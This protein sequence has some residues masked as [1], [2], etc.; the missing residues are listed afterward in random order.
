MLQAIRQSGFEPDKTRS[1]MITPAKLPA[2]L[3]G[4]PPGLFVAS[5]GL[6]FAEQKEDLF[7]LFGGHRNR[8]VDVVSQPKENSNDKVVDV[9]GDNDTHSNHQYQP[10]PVASDAPVFVAK[11]DE[12]ENGLPTV[13]C[14]EALSETSEDDSQ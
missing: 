10:S 4:I 5:S 1:G 13:Q 7:D 11:E 3:P 14:A 9:S 6:G 2:G 8:T 12:V